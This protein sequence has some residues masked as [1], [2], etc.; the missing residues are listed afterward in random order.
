MPR[1]RLSIGVRGKAMKAMC[2]AIAATLLLTHF[3][4]MDAEKH[5]PEG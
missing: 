5:I 2:P 3:L 1:L 4:I